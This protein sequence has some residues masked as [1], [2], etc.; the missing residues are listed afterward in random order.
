VPLLRRALPPAPITQGVRTCCVSEATG[1]ERFCR[2]AAAVA[3]AVLPAQGTQR[4]PGEQHRS[5]SNASFQPAWS[6][7]AAACELRHVA[8]ACESRCMRRCHLRNA[9]SA[10]ANS[11]L[12]N[13]HPLN[14]AQVPLREQTPHEVSPITT[15]VYTH[16]T[17]TCASCSG[18]RCC[19]LRCPTSMHASL[20]GACCTEPHSSQCYV[21]VH[22]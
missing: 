22:T 1:V 11:P 21:G 20:D 10:S 15:L 19:L 3:A 14:F 13:K 7:W 16:P 5:I 4:R 9:N 18:W 6:V 17:Q 12:S 8:P 2:Q